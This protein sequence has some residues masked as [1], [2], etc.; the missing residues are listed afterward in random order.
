MSYDQ[1]IDGD[2]TFDDDLTPFLSDVCGGAVSG[3]C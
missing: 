3:D 2:T 1:H